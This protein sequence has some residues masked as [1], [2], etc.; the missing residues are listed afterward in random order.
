MDKNQAASIMNCALA[1]SNEIGRTVVCIQEMPDGRQKSAFLKAIGDM[2]QI[3]T[4]DVIFP[5]AD[6]FPDLDPDR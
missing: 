5:I 6:E 3:V 2:L 1:L 4:V